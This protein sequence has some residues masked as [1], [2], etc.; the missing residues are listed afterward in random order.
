[1]LLLEALFVK[2]HGF[3]RTPEDELRRVVVGSSFRHADRCGIPQPRGSIL[4]PAALLKRCPQPLTGCL[5]PFVVRPLEDGDKFVPADAIHGGMLEGFAHHA[6]AALD[7]Q[8]PGPVPVLVVDLLQ[9]VH[10]DHD[11]G[12]VKL[13]ALDR[14]IYLISLLY[15]SGLVS[16]MC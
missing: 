10:V 2:I 12:K 7:I 8:I 4:L 9:I 3:V 14:F 15:I 5:S 6:A 1:M 11:H 16:D 13:T